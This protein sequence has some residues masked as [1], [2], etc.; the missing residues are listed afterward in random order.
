MLYT[1][2]PCPDYGLS[3]YRSDDSG[4]DIGAQRTRVYQ[5]PE[6]WQGDKAIAIPPSDVYAFAIILFEIATRMDPYEVFKRHS[7]CI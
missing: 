6:V 5:A 2:V 4:E 3:S 7:F 1:F